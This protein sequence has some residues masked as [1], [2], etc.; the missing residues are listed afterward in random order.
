VKRGPPA[1]ATRNPKAV[2]DYRSPRRWRDC[3]AP[4]LVRDLPKLTKVV[5]RFTAVARRNTSVISPDHHGNLLGH[6]G[7][8][9]QHHGDPPGYHGHPPRHRGV[10]LRHHSRPA[11]RLGEMPVVP[12]KMP[13]PPVARRFTPVN[14][15]LN[16]VNG[17]FSAIFLVPNLPIGNVLVFE[18]PIREPCSTGQASG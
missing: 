14:P 2:E 1:V 3:Q 18:S 16:S 4:E 12:G 13:P 8:P 10:L 15:S 7:D 9:P 6:R 5:C 17:G 11:S